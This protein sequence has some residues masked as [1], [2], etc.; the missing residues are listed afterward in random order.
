MTRLQIAASALVIA[1]LNVAPL[2]AQAQAQGAQQQKEFD[3][4]IE[5]ARKEARADVNTLITEAMRFSAD[6]AAKFWPMFKTYEAKRKALN[7]ERLALIK[8]FAAN[9][10]TLNDAKAKQ[11]M[12]NALAVEEKGLSA[13]KQFL[14]EMGKAFPAKT[15]ARFAQVHSR[16]ELLVDVM[17]AQGIPLVH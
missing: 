8:D 1:G 2:H 15:V 5:Q 7:D 17:L 16:I 11:L 6:D 3:A 12:D 9:Y 14:A 10:G 4:A 13:K